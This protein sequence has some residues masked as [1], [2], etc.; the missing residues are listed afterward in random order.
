M[1]L[2]TFIT[3]S[4]LQNGSFFPFLRLIIPQSDRE[5]DA[6]G[7]RTATLGKLYVRALAVNKESEVALKLTAQQGM[8]TQCVD[9]SDIVFEVMKSRAPKDSTMTVYEVNQYLDLI[10]NHFKQNERSSE[11]MIFIFKTVNF[12][13]SSESNILFVFYRKRRT[14]HSNDEETEPLGPEMV[15]ANHSEENELG[16]GTHENPAALSPKCFGLL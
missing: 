12:D 15:N 7:I 2:S 16:S 8:K 4:K 6:M 11:L 3:I 1:I 13:L 10:S 5:R 14:N 9:Y